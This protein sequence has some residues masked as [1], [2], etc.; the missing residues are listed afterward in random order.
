MPFNISFSPM[1]ILISALALV[2][3]FILMKSIMRIPA[4][5]N[6]WVTKNF[7]KKIEDGGFLA[8]NGEAGYQ[9]DPIQNGWRFKLWPLFT[10]KVE[11]LTQIPAGTVGVVISQVGGALPTGAKS[12]FYRDDFGDFVD[13]R[14]FVNNGGQQG[15]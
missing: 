7:G 13:V 11:P 6:G 4:G 3:L 12:A 1:L 5:Y 2:A 10:V 9:P 15:V 8:L 14:N